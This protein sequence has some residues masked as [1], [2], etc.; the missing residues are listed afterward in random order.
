MANHASS[1]KRI[2]RNARRAEINGARRSRMRTFIK[3]VELA[4]T[5]GDAK[6]ADEAFKA[7][8]PEIDRSVA[9]GILHKNTAARKL[10]RLSSRISA[11]KKA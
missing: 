8:Q 4:L 2:R 1:K 7:A 10:S 3:K 5:A 6:A 11:L 9:K